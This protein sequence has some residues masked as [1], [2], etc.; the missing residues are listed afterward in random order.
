MRSRLVLFGLLILAACEYDPA[1]LLSYPPVD[2]RVAE[3]LDGSLA[4]PAPPR[5]RPDS[6]RFAIF[7]DIHT[8]VGTTELLD[9]F[10]ADVRERG[11]DFFCVAGD[12]TDEA[13]ADQFALCRARLDSVGVPY[14]V[15]T[16]N[17]DLYSTGGWDRYKQTFGP[18]CYALP[19]ANRLLLLFIDSAEGVIGEPQFAWLEEQLA[20]PGYLKIVITHFPL[21]D[22][23]RPTMWRFASPAERYRL[24][25]LLERTG[26]T[27]L[28]SGHIHGW[29]HT[30]VNGVDHFIIAL[31]PNGTDYGRPGYLLYTFRGDS[32]SWE[33]V[34]Y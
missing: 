28:V 32:L 23:D 6:F 18:S 19:V 16:G 3:C 11:I 2:T 12:L 21:W 8:G 27:A 20:R 4:W 30:A 24:Q 22:G 1:A 33:N 15:T 13:T 17:H 9:R 31:S 14:Y 10:R 26:A 25:D 29:R 7:G 34:E 5:P